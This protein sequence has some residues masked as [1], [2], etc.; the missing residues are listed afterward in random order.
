M[1]FGS[2]T[3]YD[4]DSQLIGD[5]ATEWKL[6]GTAW[7]FKLRDGVIWHDGSPFT[8][9]DVKYTF[10]RILDPDVGSFPVPRSARTQGSRWSIR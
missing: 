6:D 5:L 8:A 3:T 4:A 9:D 10:E 1:I 2:L 7:V